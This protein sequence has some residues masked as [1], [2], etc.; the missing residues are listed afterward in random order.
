MH[1]MGRKMQRTVDHDYAI[2]EDPLLSTRDKT[3]IQLST[4]AG[5]ELLV[6]EATRELD[7]IARARPPAS[8]AVK[9]LQK[10]SIPNWHKV[11]DKKL[12]KIINN[13]DEIFKKVENIES[14]LQKGFAQV[15]KEQK[16]VFRKLQDTERFFKEDRDR[17]CPNL[18]FLVERESA[19]WAT[20]KQALSPT[21]NVRLRF[22]CEAMYNNYRPHEVKHKQGLDGFA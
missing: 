13:Q 11:V 16:K 9:N 6:E 17:I 15:L 18:I 21:V 19:S 10:L 2:T 7:G 12:D 3:G 20:L 8:V 4:V 1:G 22:A 5:E 14:M